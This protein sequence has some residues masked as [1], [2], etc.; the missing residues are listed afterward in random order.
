M[1]STYT[2]NLALELIGTGDQT[3]TWGLTTNTNLGTLLE[4]AISGYG[5]TTVSGS[6]T[7]TIPNGASGTGRN[8]VIAVSGTGGTLY[9]PDTNAKLYVIFNAA[10]GAVTVQRTSGGSSVTVPAGK[11]AILYCDGT[12]VVDTVN[13]LSSLT[14]TGTAAT[15][16]QILTAGGTTTGNISF[17]MTNTSGGLIIGAESSAGG[18]LITG[19]AAY[20]TAIKTPSQPLYLSTNAGT[21]ACLVANTSGEIILGNGDTAASPAAGTLRGAN[22]SGSN[23]AGA[24][25]T[26]QSG[27]GTGTGS[28]GSLIFKTAP[29]GSS[30]S[31]L[32]TAANRLVIDTSGNVGVGVTPTGS[33]GILQIAGHA[34]VQTLLEKATI[35]ATAATGTINFDV[36]TQPVL[37]YTSNASAN[38]TINIRGDSTTTLNSIM[39]TGQSMTVAFLVT[40]GTT[41]YY[42]TVL[43][44][45]GTSVTPKWQGSTPTSGNASSVDVY[46]ITIIKTASA[47]YTVF[48]SQTKFA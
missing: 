28:G 18:S 17:G 46:V 27:I 10:S 37:Y 41:A 48:E 33:N 12:N 3:G 14:L 22:G 4:Q 26:I 38:W 13:S 23:V 47:T 2:T 6:T 25:L 43:Q 30:G 21:S 15:N 40:Q 34:S 32:N 7:L 45:D 42:Q 1:A 24:N 20:A 9:V 16:T 11:K 31:S 35:S 8:M 44:I 19:A 5:S 36:L 29:A 39:Q